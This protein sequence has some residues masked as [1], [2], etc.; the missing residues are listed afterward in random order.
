L[1]AF[2]S[3]KEQKN[4]TFSVAA[5]FFHKRARRTLHLQVHKG[6]SKGISLCVYVSLPFQV[7]CQQ[8]LL[9]FYSALILYSWLF[10]C[11]SLTCR[12]RLIYP[13]KLKTPEK[14]LCNSLES[15]ECIIFSSLRQSLPCHPFRPYRNCLQLL[16]LRI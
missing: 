3:Q 13:L 6:K 16:L 2:F 14:C 15:S 1:A 5:F 7:S 9:H 10:L 4:L 11:N 8:S 12:P